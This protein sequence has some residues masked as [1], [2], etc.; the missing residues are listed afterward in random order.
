MWFL[1]MS[2]YAES[3]VFVA[4]I[5]SIIA[6]WQLGNYKKIGWLFNLAA[7]GLWVIFALEVKCWSCLIN[8]I[9]FAVLAVRGWVLWTRK[10]N[11]EVI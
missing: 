2:W 6:K 11:E 9:V 5:F 8:N 10:D 4:M 3:L 1:L 7:I